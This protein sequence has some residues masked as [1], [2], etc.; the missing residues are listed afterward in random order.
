MSTTILANMSSNNTVFMMPCGTVY[1]LT[2]NSTTP[3]LEGWYCGTSA[4]D[5]SEPGR[6]SNTGMLM[7]FSSVECG[8]GSMF[9]LENGATILDAYLCALRHNNT[10]LAA[11]NSGSSRKYP[12]WKYLLFSIC[13]L[14][15]AAVL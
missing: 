15:L 11:T 13:V 2:V 3:V 12:G 7:N 6:Y 10:C 14:P 8:D 1:N 5:N 9:D 4:Y